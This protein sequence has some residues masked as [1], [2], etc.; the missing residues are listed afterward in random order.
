MWCSSQWEASRSLDK[1]YVRI[2]FEK[3]LFTGMLLGR[4]G[5]L[6]TMG[7]LH[8]VALASS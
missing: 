4:V 6:K 2:K 7:Q 8:Q 3:C 5:E 1:G